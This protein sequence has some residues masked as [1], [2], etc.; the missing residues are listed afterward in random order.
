MQ[1]L[2]CRQDL[3]PWAWEPKG[4]GGSWDPRPPWCG[5]QGL[6]R[7]TARRQGFPEK[8]SARGARRR[9]RAPTLACLRASVPD[10]QPAT[11]AHQP[12]TPPSWRLADYSRAAA[13]SSWRPFRS[14]QM[15][16]I[17]TR[18]RLRTRSRSKTRTKITNTTLA[19]RLKQSIKH[20]ILQT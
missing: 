11:D 15:M 10:Q 20:D 2:A 3:G 7:N 13:R 19:H 5:V 1:G 17:I 9:G 8:G 12:P 16:I 6:P 14:R 4:L 18:T